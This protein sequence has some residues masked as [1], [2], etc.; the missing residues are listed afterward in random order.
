MKLGYACINTTLS[1]GCKFKTI[2]VKS[3]S[4]LTQDE[5][6][7]KVKGITV[8]NLYNTYKILQWNIENKIYMYRMS[9]NL[10]PLATHELLK[11]WQWWNDK[12]VINICSKI[13]EFITINNIR[14]SFHPDQFCV[15]NSPKEEVFQMA[16]G[17]LE[18]HN[19][20]SD[21]VGNNTLILH[22]GGVYGNKET[23]IRRFIDNFNRLPIDIQSKIVLENDDK[24]F[25]VNNVLTIC[26]ILNIRMCVDF[27]HDRCLPTNESIKWYIDDI[28]ATWKGQ[29]PKCH[30]STG[31]DN[32]T[33]RSH[34]DYVSNEDFERVVELTKGKFDIMFECKVKELSILEYIKEGI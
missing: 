12:D 3:A 31:K 27:H 23:A 8:D 28:I 20:L 32:I 34:A 15:I 19:K 22:V 29:K 17:I 5:L 25:N 30:L 6:I 4:K 11:D 13:K 10:I 1:K 18:Y 14:I 26:K 21:M 2:T 24:S 7:K 9:S 33:D 16:V